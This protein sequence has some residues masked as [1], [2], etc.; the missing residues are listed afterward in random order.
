MPCAEGPEPWPAQQTPLGNGETGPWTGGLVS[1]HRATEWQRRVPVPVL[2]SVAG[3]PL[4]EKLVILGQACSE[5][6]LPA[7]ALLNLE[8]L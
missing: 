3:L 6:S 1:G 2:V 7:Q 4:N 5:R 8:S